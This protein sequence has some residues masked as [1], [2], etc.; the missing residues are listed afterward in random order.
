MNEEI[1]QSLE[2][3][4]V[5]FIRVLWCDNANII[6]GKAVYAKSFQQW[7]GT[8]VGISEAQMGVPVMYDALV[9]GS[10]LSPA[11]EVHLMPDW[12]SCT[13]LPYAQGHARVM[14]DMMKKGEPWPLCPRGFLRKIVAAAENEDLEIKCSFENEFYLL[15]ELVDSPVPLDYTPFAAT[16]AMD[17]SKNVIEDITR[18]LIAQ[19]ITVEQ[20]YPESGPGQ[21]EI[22]MHY[23]TP[24]QAADNQIAFRETVHATALHHGMRASFMP[25]LFGD[26][27]GSGCHIHM[28]LWQK[29]QNITAD[30]ED[31]HGIS[32]ATRSFIAG[33]LE[34]LPALMAITVPVPNSYKRLKPHCWSGAFRCWGPDNREAAV[35]TISDPV[36]KRVW[37]F[38]FKTIDAA[39]NPY[40]AMAAV[41][42]AGLD[43]VKRNI[44]LASPALSDP[45]SLSVKEMMDLG[46]ER[47]PEHPDVSIGHL[48]KDEVLLNAMGERLAKAFIA[49]RKAEC[50]AMKNFKH[51]E[52]VEMLADKY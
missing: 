9:E 19:G 37:S 31:P 18:A 46:I 25:K 3:S 24:M 7:Y 5:E 45:G 8:G 52:E 39:S 44:A 16:Y 51:V 48:E 43:G 11:G 10:G 4:G 38:E 6:R 36:G 2:S 17:F 42:A 34:H 15:K 22:T 30:G 35:R 14:G 12:A 49:V 50:A 26:K 23:T 32:K 13:S 47:L 29:G 28:S 21:A 1:I 40:I 20:Y 27:A 33:L 41:I